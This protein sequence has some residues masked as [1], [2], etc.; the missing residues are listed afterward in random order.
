MGLKH[1]S[2]QLLDGPAP[3]PTVCLLAAIDF[4]LVGPGREEE[5][6]WTPPVGE[7]FMPEVGAQEQCPQKECR[8]LTPVS[9]RAPHGRRCCLVDSAQWPLTSPPLTSLCEGSEGLTRGRVWEGRMLLLNH[10]SSESDLL[11]S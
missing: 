2:Q 5:G 6:A 1:E 11:E 7:R 8:G 10:V 4:K 3:P 9:D